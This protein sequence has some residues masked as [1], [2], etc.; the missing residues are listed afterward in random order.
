[1]HN[2]FELEIRPIRR[3]VFDSNV[4][5]NVSFGLYSWCYA[6][7]SKELVMPISQVITTL[8]NTALFEKMLQR[9][10]AVGN[11]VSYLTGLKFEPKTSHSR[12]KCVTARPTGSWAKIV[13]RNQFNQDITNSRWIVI[14]YGRYQIRMEF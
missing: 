12:N 7:A 9:W 4:K 10:R 13:A 2:V 1:M 5:S 14:E 6:E 8:S 11:T 3:C